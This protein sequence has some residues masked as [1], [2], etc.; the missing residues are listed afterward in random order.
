MEERVEKR[1]SVVRLVGKAVVKA[2]T[3]LT[4]ESFGSLADS[5]TAFTNNRHNLT[6]NSGG[7]S[8]FV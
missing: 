4:L 1:V 7:A 3:Q 5:A 8:Q 6:S 2:A